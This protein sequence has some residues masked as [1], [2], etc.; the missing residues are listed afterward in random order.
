[1]PKNMPI[2]SLKHRT[3]SIIADDADVI[4]QSRAKHP[5]FLPKPEVKPH[6]VIHI[7]TTIVTEQTENKYKEQ[8]EIVVPVTASSCCLIS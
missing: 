6:T 7:S 2:K 4:I 1:M 8:K 5:F 3:I